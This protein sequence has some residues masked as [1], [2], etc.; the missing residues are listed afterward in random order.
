MIRSSTNYLAIDIDG[1]GSPT[2]RWDE[3]RDYCLDIGSN[4]A[5]I[6]SSAQ[7]TEVENLMSLFDDQYWW[8]GATSIGFTFSLYPK[9][10]IWNK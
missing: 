7:Q 9:S 6:H 10:L 8:L 5:S 2:V 1:N 4:L 3:A